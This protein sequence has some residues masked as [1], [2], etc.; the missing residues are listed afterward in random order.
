MNG[1]IY[2]N[3]NIVFALPGAQ[4]QNGQ[5]AIKAA[6]EIIHPVTKTS[7][8]VNNIRMLEVETCYTWTQTV[9]VDGVDYGTTVL[10]ETCSTT[11]IDDSGGP[12]GSGGSPGPSGTGGSGGTAPS[13]PPPCS[14]PSASQGD[15]V[16]SSN[17]HAITRVAAPPG[18]F[19]RPTST[20]NPCPQEIVTTTVTPTASSVNTITDSVTNPCLKAIID[21]LTNNQT[22]QTNVTSVLRNTFGVNDQVN[23]T[24]DQGTLTGSYSTAD[25]N[26]SGNQLNNLVVTFNTPVIANASKEFLLETTMHEIFH[27]Y[28]YVNPT[29]RTGLSQHAYMIQNYVNTE[30]ATLQQVFPNLST[31]DAQCLV[32]GGYADLDPTTLNT[33]LTTFNLTSGDVATTDN[34]YKSGTSGT[35]CP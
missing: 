30:V 33:A 18:G 4:T 27:A 1:W 14:V 2:K 26:T 13:Q 32:L 28:L 5:A 22:I 19:P 7:R 10:D 25:A 31:H 21:N 12:S 34:N 17:N 16:L 6:N 3:G 11:Y 35:Q 23:I 24:F 15:A 9:T 8:F 20:T 29:V